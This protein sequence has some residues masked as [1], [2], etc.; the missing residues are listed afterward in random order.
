MKSISL[1]EICL[2]MAPANQGL[3]VF[4]FSTFKNKEEI[5]AN[6]YLLIHN[7]SLVTIHFRIVTFQKQ[8]YE[9]V[10]EDVVKGLRG[11]FNERLLM[12]LQQIWANKLA[13][14]EALV[15]VPDAPETRVNNQLTRRK[16]SAS[17]SA[18]RLHSQPA[19]SGK[20]YE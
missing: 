8:L 4:T 15:Q 19:A 16:K 10:I 14:S 20:L 18:R 9:G 6:L 1:C 2:E 7:H 11:S 5:R 17:L 13:A 12:K 3:V